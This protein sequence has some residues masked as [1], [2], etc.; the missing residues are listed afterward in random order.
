[1]GLDKGPIVFVECRCDDVNIVTVSRQTAGKA[2]GKSSRA[3]Y[4][5]REGIAANHD[6]QFA[7]VCSQISGQ[8][9]S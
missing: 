5:W 2:L 7:L 1:M 3:V 4:V 8:N 6:A 9:T